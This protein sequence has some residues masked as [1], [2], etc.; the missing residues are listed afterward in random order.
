VSTWYSSL[1]ILSP[2]S[3]DSGTIDLEEFY[4]SIREKQSAFGNGIFNLIGQL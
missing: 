3:S 4:A 2:L 1:L